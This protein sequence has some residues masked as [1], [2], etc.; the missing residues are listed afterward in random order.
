MRAHVHPPEIGDVSRAAPPEAMP[1]P[2][3]EP[4][5]PTF[6][7][8]A[9]MDSYKEAIKGALESADSAAEAVTTGSFSVA[10][11]YAALL[12]LVT[13]ETDVAPV[14]AILPIFLFAG[15]ALAALIARSLGVRTGLHPNTVE[16]VSNDISRTIWAKRIGA[17]VGIGLLV[18]A[19]GL[20]GVVVVTQY[21]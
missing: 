19:L 1:S 13:A 5:L 21:A 8:Q 15:A 2:D 4:R 9:V 12:G 20:A 11:A 6:R 18:L 14:P 10:T 17:W 16:G 3:D 7:E